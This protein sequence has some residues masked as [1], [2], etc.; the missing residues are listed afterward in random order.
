MLLE[1]RTMLSGL[2]DLVVSAAAAPG[3]AIANSSIN[4][5]WTVQNI[6]SAA[7]P[8]TWFD[9]VFIG[10]SPTFDQ[11]SDTVINSFDESAQS[12]L[13]AGASYTDNESI[14]LPA[15]AASG[16]EY[17]IFVANYGPVYYAVGIATSNYQPGHGETNYAANSYAVPITIQTPDLKLTTATAPSPA[18]ANSSINVSWTVQNVGSVAALGKWSDAVYIGSSPN[19]DQNRDT[20]ID[21]NWDTPINNFDESAQSPLAAGASYT[22]RESITLPAT[23]AAG[24]DYLFFVT[25]DYAVEGDFFDA[26]GETDYTNNIDAIPV[27]VSAPVPFQ[28]GAPVLVSADD[29]GNK[30]DE[31]TD[32][33]SPRLTGT[34][35]ANATVELLNNANSV[36]ATTTADASGIYVVPVPGR[37]SPGTYTFSVVASNTYGSSPASQPLSLTI[38][39]PPASPTAPTLL[40]ADSNGSPGGEATTSATP[41]LTG[42]TAAGTTVQLLNASGMVVN[43]IKANCTG[44]YQIEVPGPLTVGSYQFQVDAID[45]YGDLSTLSAAR[46]ITVVNPPAPVVDR[47]I[48]GTKRGS[49]QS[50]AVYFSEAMTLASAGAS[51]DYTLLDAGSS[52][53]CSGERN[54]GITLKS[55][56]YSSADNEATLTLAEA[57]RRRDSLRLTLN[58]QPP[59]GL[60]GANGQFLNGAANGTPG[61]NDVI[62]LGAPRKTPPATKPKKPAKPPKAPKKE[63]TNAGT[64]HVAAKGDARD[65]GRVAIEGLNATSAAIARPF[66]AALDSLLERKE[67]IDLKRILRERRLKKSLVFWDGQ[68]RSKDLLRLPQ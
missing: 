57:V 40:P 46:T 38:V 37:L 16:S 44:V 52:R 22:D 30:G 19:F 24:T 59:S 64:T 27:Q 8:G 39:L 20:P 41:Y 1:P 47:T 34:T 63:S 58:A 67:M 42:I 45:Q 55:V 60:Q 18:I 25:N 33:A 56:T 5:S 66:R 14:T 61:A 48:L 13:S 17:L 53:V 3:S 2:P 23:A 26:Q 62:Y 7:A 28:R 12:P 51:N 29:S 11:T 32:I 65:D 43:T 21:Q 35:Q 49:I 31:I 10:S 4:V 6:G 68:V 36:V 50:I 9:S 15:S 54:A